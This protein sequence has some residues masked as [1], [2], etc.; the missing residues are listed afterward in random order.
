MEE[1]EI[2][3]VVLQRG[4]I[5][6]GQ[7]VEETETVLRI[8]NSSVIRRWGTKKG[9]GELTPGPLVT[10]ILDKCGTVTAHPLAVV[11]QIECSPEGWAK[12]V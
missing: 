1:K 2:R 8:E 11:M 3:I 9:I 6:V 5:V 4:W 10:T 12:H 7:V